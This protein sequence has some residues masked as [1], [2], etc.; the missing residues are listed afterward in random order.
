MN[1]NQEMYIEDGIR[2]LKALI[3]YDKQGYYTEEEV[4]LITTDIIKLITK[5]LK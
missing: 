5:S 1:A 2:K 3:Y 4:K